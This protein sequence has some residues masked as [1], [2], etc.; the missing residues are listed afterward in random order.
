MIR[1]I[2]A[3]VKQGYKTQPFPVG[4]DT[5]PRRYLGKPLVVAGVPKEHYDKCRDICPTGAIEISPDRFTLDMGKCLFCG[6]CQKVC[7]GS[8]V[9]FS[10]EYRL[11]ARDKK[12]LI[13]SPDIEK[14]SDKTK[15]KIKNIFGRSLKLRQVSAGGCNACEADINVL[16]TLSFDLGRFGVQFVASPRHAD[17]LIITG[18]VTDNMKLA[19]EKTYKAV[20]SPKIVIAAGACAISGGPYMGHKTA[21][22]GVDSIIPV[23]VYVP[24]CPPHPLSILDGILKVMGR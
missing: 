9:S 7:S 23:D 14:F 24:G 13:I 2:C 6:E 5:L 21:N 16:N 20:A 11:A 4:K 18:P 15:K 17:G 3:R 19:L 22:N 1:T 12:D 10:R 8:C